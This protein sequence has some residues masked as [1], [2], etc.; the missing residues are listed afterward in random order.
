M[1]AQFSIKASL[2]DSSN[3]FVVAIYDSTADDVVVDFKVPTK[4][5]SAPYYSDQFQVTFENLTAK[6]YVLKLWESPDETVQ[7][8]VRN[9]TNF[10]PSNNKAVV[11]ADLIIIADLTPGFYSNQQGYTDATLVGWEYS[12]E[13]KGFG[14]MVPA[15]LDITSDPDY[16]QFAAGNGWILSK[17][18][19]VIQNQE[20][21]IHRFVPQI[22]EEDPPSPTII[23]SGVIIDSDITLDASYVNKA[24]YIQ[25][26]SSS[27]SITL[28][29]LSTVQ[30]YQMLIFYSAGGSHISAPIYTS[31]TDKILVGGYLKSS[32]IINQYEQFKI[33]KANGI[34]N[35]DYISP[36]ALM[37]GDIVYRYDKPGL[38][39]LFMDGTTKSRTDYARLYEYLVNFNLMISDATW[40]NVQIADDIPYLYNRGFF[41]NGNGSTT[42]RLP[43][44]HA[45][46][47][48]EAVDGSTRLAGS[49]KKDEMMSHHHTTLIGTF[50]GTPY[51][52]SPTQVEKGNFSGRETGY[53]DQVSVPT[54]FNGGALTRTGTKT[55]TESFGVYAMVRI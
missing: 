36:T 13:R 34:W 45:A 15:S 3:Y 2:N 48:L 9:S 42:F 20:V 39:M 23:S 32:Q 46:G 26:L 7:G 40:G 27:V 44:I 38:N 33:F 22:V 5:A 37:V 17:D 24:L 47:Y 43:M 55:R 49:H 10:Q 28:P 4:N 12:V 53:R 52:K 11:R 16:E 25:G 18:G 51:G 14:T 54:N 30:D 21:F 6:G 31:G 35:V 8:T 50:P 19:D 29:L 1:D 41:S